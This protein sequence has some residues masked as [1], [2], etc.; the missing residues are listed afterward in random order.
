MCSIGEIEYSYLSAIYENIQPGL[1]MLRPVGDMIVESFI[2]I[3]KA[4]TMVYVH[5]LEMAETLIT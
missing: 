3:A 4:K 2:Q 5:L 1:R